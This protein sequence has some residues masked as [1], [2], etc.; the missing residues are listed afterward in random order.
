MRRASARREEIRAVVD[1][2]A[3]KPFNLLVGSASK[4]TVQEIGDLG[5]RRVSVGG[6]MARAAWGGFMRAAKLLA[7]EGKFDGLAD[8][9]AGKDLNSLFR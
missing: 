8:A 6:A 4:L 5:V 9:A 7:A 1:A 3:P 2:V